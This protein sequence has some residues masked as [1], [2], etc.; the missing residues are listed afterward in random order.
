MRLSDWLG[1]NNITHTEMADRIGGVTPEAVRL[2][3]GGERM[4]EVKWITRIVEVT[5]G[6]VGISDL[7]EARLETMSAKR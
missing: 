1:Q 4:P 3:A 5:G 7:Y 2:W 6:E